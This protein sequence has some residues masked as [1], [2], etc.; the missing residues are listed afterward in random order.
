MLQFWLA[1]GS[2]STTSADLAR[3]REAQ[4]WDGQMFMDSQSL[5][6]D[7]WV[8]MGA[9]AMVTERIQLCTSTTNP[10][11]RHPAVTAA[12]A[13]SV[14]SVS[15]GRAALGIGRG[16][17]ALAYLGH[18]PA[19]PAVFEQSLRDLQALLGG[20]EVNFAEHA[21]TAAGANSSAS[22]SL[23]HRPEAARLKW[24]PD[25]LPKVP[26][27]VAA[28]GPKVIAMSAPLAER[29]TFSV[30]AIPERLDW[31][32]GIAREARGAA[33]LGDDGISYGA[34]VIV[35]CHP[36][37]D[38]VLPA[39]TSFVA[40]LARFQVIQGAAAGPLAADDAANFAAIRRGYDMNRH[41]E[42]ISAEKL[43]GETLTPEFVRRFAI[44]GSPE[45]CIERLLALHDQGLER[46][47]I[48]GPG[49]HP[50]ADSRGPGLFVS[51]VMPA[52]RAELARR[53]R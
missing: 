14:Q 20:G 2:E 26:L 48:V 31:A 38:A 39:A 52:V 4:G 44:V 41:S 1:G 25:D 27:D 11:T 5:S 3:E 15:G 46:L 53:G 6:A 35:V 49:F 34:Q 42:A 12:C 32:M 50:E 22:L 36:D 18:A 29:V 16:D 37:L 51:E 13:A 8:L 19:R 28:T 40:P 24:L 9:W 30:G 43:G 10:L 23:G 45:H 47:V 7:P 17:S 21:T 33:G